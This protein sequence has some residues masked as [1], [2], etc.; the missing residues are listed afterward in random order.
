MSTL[1]VLSAGAAKG[2]VTALAEPFRQAS[3]HTLQCQFGAVGAMQERLDAGDP[4]DLIIL[5]R[6]M[7]DVLARSGRVDVAATADLGRVRTGVAVPAGAPHPTV[8]DEAGLRSALQRASAIYIPDPVR[9]TA[10]IH[11]MKVLAALGLSDE[12]AARLRAYPNGAAAMGEMARA[13]DSASIGVTQVTEI[14]YTIGVELVAPLPAAF[15]L[16]TVYTAAVS[17]RT[18]AHDAAVA[19]L[20]QL[21]GSTSKPLRRAG[22]FEPA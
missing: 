11:C 5:S 2:L 7:I 10:G 16:A 20:Q 4:C 15:E 6:A 19:L 12:V 18:S 3:G 9:S 22:G 17:A 21:T 8:A 14:L 13:A 1:H